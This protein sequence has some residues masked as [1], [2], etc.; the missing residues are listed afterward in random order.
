MRMFRLLKS[1]SFLALLSF[2]LV[3]VAALAQSIPGVSDPI[4]LVVSP[5]FPEPNSTVTVR[6]Q[7]FSTDLN[8][9]TLTWYSGGKIILKGVGATDVSVP[10]GA[11]GSVSDVSV[12]VDTPDLG[13]FSI[14]TSWRP[15]SVTLLWETDGYIP[16]FYR[17]K[18]LEV[19]GSSFRVTALPEFFS[20]T[21]KRIDPKTLVYL[22]QKNGTNIPEQSGYGKQ[23]FSSI[24]TSYV[25]GGDEISVEVSTADHTIVSSGSVTLSPGT[26]DIVLYEASPLYGIRYETALSSRYTLSAEEVSLRA[27]PFDISAGNLL[28][29]T[30]SFDWTMN[31]ATLSA[32]QDKPEVTLRTSGSIGGQSEIGLQIQHRSRML[33]GGSAGI[34]ILQ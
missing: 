30:L 2:S 14:E 28:S 12:Q 27:V 33:Q 21:G 9:A 13:T 24:Q 32:F 4:T 7:S 18:S 20:S 25:R 22:W 1:I 17:G 34:T 11:A 8:R 3:P 5:Q 31:G 26:P 15:A 10:S 29:G 23:S 16:P 6:A 19:Y